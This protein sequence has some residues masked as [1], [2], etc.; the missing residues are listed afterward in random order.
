MTQERSSSLSLLV[1]LSSR[2]WTGDDE[3]NDRVT[4]A[5]KVDHM[6]L[7]CDVGKFGFQ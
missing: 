5:V 6:L 7:N 2:L 3:T 4:R 1:S